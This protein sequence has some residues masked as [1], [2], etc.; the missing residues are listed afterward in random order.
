METAALFEQ[1]EKI[2]MPIRMGIFAGTILLLAF[3]F[4]YFLYL[5]K[6]EEIKKTQ[7]EIKG[8]EQKVNRAKIRAKNLQKFE[9]ESSLVEAQFQEALRLLPNSKEIPALL[10]NLSE[11]GAEAGLEFNH[12]SQQKENPGDF[13]MEIPVSL[14][15]SGSYHNVAVFFDKVGSMERIVNILN[16][17][18]KPV[19]ARSTT[20]ITTCDAVTYRF[21]GES[22]VEETKTKKKSKK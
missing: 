10:R 2:R 12:F 19:D 15:L 8:L 22:D 1:V 16:V 14:E 18:M 5:P 9:E 6:T 13:Y 4:I 17:S 11:L 3:A 21:K 20:L 7:S